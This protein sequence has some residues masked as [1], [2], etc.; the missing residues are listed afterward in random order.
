MKEKGSLGAGREELS[1]LPFGVWRYRA[2]LP[3]PA[4]QS[5]VTLGEGGTPLL[6]AERLGGE[7]G[8]SN[9]LL[10]DETRNPTGSFIDRGSTVL[11]TLA[12]AA[13]IKTCSCTTTG[14]L[15]ASLAAYCAK[16]GIAAKV[17]IGRSTDRGKLYQMVAFGADVE[18]ASSDERDTE[19]PS[20][21]VTAGNPYILAGEKTT[22]FEIAQDLGWQPPDVIMLPVGTG[23]HISMVWRALDEMRGAGLL[24][25]SPCRLIGVRPGGDSPPKGWMMVS[26]AAREEAL[27]P[28]LEESE[29]F[30]S[31]EAARVIKVSGGTEVVTTTSDS[32][33][34]TGLLART[35][36]I[37]AEPASAS[38]V[39]ALVKARSDGTIDADE[40]VVCVI[41]GAGL[42]DPKS[43]ARVAKAA[44]KVAVNEPFAVA[45]IQIGD[46]KLEI[47]RLLGQGPGFGYRLWKELGSSRA[48][49][50]ASV[51]QH[52]EELEELGLVRRSGL[53]TAKGRER[54]FYDLTRR[55]S[56]YLAMAGKM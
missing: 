48:I 51:Y 14:N 26:I 5:V 11:V 18:A 9:L 55:G 43:I 54:V 33:R 10:K 38:V 16:A 23:G 40:K 31:K 21:S 45:R 22:C 15:G 50:T 46:T 36:G 30:F 28:E 17:R 32:I 1:R 41:T 24:E 25:R 37:F 27:I 13:G 20:L 19:V 3:V 34:A 49:S 2:F 52:L 42:K 4:G 35:E 47:L 8:L 7:V 44:R 39:A 12:K 6:R 53:V 56:D 29:P